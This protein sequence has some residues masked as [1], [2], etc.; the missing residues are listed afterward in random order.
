MPAAQT[1]FVFNLVF[2]DLK[3]GLRGGVCSFNLAFIGA[4]IANE[5]GSMDVGC[6]MLIVPSR[7][8]LFGCLSA[9]VPRCC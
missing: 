1:F 2:L 3:I 4:A 6:M 9:G 8:P 5:T 7:R